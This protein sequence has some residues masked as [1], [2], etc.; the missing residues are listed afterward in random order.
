MTFHR[1]RRPHVEAD[2]APGLTPGAAALLSE[3]QRF[4][5]AVL[6]LLSDFVSTDQDAAELAERLLGEWMHAVLVRDHS[7]VEAIRQWHAENQPGALVLLPV[8]SGPRIP[9]NGPPRGSGPLEARLKAEGPAAPWVDALLSGSEVL[10]R[11]GHALRRASGAILLAGT[12]GSG[13]PL[14]RRAEIG[15]LESEIAQ[16]EAVGLTV[17]ASLAA[18]ELQLAEL[19]RTAAEAGAKRSTGSLRSGRTRRER[20]KT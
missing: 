18:T 16:Q 3:R 14:R 11:R 1:Q 7:S 8:D 4:N 19:E 10:D 13:G 9:G 5:G 17:C 2:V 6:G 12:T 20:S 15:R